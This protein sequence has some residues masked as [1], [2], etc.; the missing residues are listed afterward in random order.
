MTTMTTN[1]L[2]NENCKTMTLCISIVMTSK[3]EICK[4]MLLCTKTSQNYGFMHVKLK[5]FA[6][7]VKK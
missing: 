4:T 1:D 6:Q 7:A 2:K 3:N 5:I